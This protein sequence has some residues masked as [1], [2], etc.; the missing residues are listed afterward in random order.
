M[1]EPV[2]PR[3]YRSTLRAE[4]ARRT[5]HAILEAAHRLFT[6][7]GYA[8]T[9][10][11]AIAAEAG[12]A[13]D[14]VYAVAGTKPTLF[15]LLLETAISGTDEAVPAEE[16]DYV[17]RIREAPTAPAKI[18]TY[19]AALRRIGQRMAPLLMVLREAAAQ[20]PELEADRSEIAERRARNMRLFA[21]DLHGTG[22][23]RDDLTIDEV[24]D[25]VWTMNSAEFYA[26]LVHDRG[27]SPERFESWLAD[28]WCRLLLAAPV[29]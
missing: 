2:K 13:V 18:A 14:T 16:R 29:R 21:A 1:P 9:T 5:R 17:L 12:V 4:R 25:I 26:L 7:R 6:E 11:A 20:A 15:R 27:W 19:A 23:L 3:A 8:A 10:I 24:A 22:E 28:A